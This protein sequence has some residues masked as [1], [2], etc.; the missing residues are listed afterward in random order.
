MAGA[1]GVFLSKFSDWKFCPP[2]KN[3]WTVSF[4]VHKDGTSVAN[5]SFSDLYSNII[6]VNENFLSRVSTKWKIGAPKSTAEF[7]DKLQDKEIGLFLATDISFAPSSVNVISKNT[8]FNWGGWLKT[9]SYQNGREQDFDAKI[10]FYSTNW[11]INELLLDPW[12]AAVGQQGLIE[13]DDTLNVGYYNIKADIT[14]CEYACSKPNEKT[15]TWVLRKTIILKKAYPVKRA[16]YKYDYDVP[17]F[18]SPGEATFD[19]E[20]YSIIY[21]EAITTTTNTN[22]A[23]NTNNKQDIKVQIQYGGSSDNPG[24]PGYPNIPAQEAYIVKN[25]SDN[26]ST[27]A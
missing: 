14:I 20:N 19:F 21:P 6:N 10:R 7:I 9:P 26:F 16:Q 17:N 11:D 15:D 8:K 13:I 24:T 12:I 18:T 25:S 2:S 1:L 3:L 22:N 23:T 4:S 27:Y 5:N